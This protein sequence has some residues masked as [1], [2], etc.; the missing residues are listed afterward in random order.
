M[1]PLAVLIEIGDG[2]RLEHFLRVMEIDLKTAEGG[3][4]A[5]LALLLSKYACLEALLRHGISPDSADELGFCG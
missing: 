1:D 5:R 3:E 2:K 4:R